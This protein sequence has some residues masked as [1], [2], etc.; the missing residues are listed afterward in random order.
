MLESWTISVSDFKRCCTST[1]DESRN[2][3]PKTATNDEVVNK[4]ND[5]MLADRPLKTK[6][7]AETPASQED[8]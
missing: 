1:S 5:V 6:E 7:T 2:G 4:I 8:A 3:L